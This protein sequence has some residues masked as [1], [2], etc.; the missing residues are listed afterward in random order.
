[1]L[2]EVSTQTPPGTRAI[3]MGHL[4][5]VAISPDGKTAAVAGDSGRVKLLDMATMQELGDLVGHTA[6]VV[7]VAFGPDGKSLASCGDD[8]TI[9]LWDPST[10]Q[11]RALLKGHAGPVYSV[12]FSPDGKTLA[13][14]SGDQT[15]KLWNVAT[16]QVRADLR[17]HT[18]SIWTVAFSPDGKTLASG[19]DDSTIKLWEA[20]S[21]RE[22]RTLRG[23]SSKVGSVAFSHDGG[24]L[25]S[26]D[27]L[28]MR[29]WDATTGQ[30][31]EA[32]RPIENMA[33][34]G[35][36]AALADGRTLAIGSQAA[37]KLWDV[38]TG[39]ERA[40]LNA[41]TGEISSVAISPD[42]RIIATTSYDGSAKF[43]RTA[44]EQD[45]LRQSS[46]LDLREKLGQSDTKEALQLKQDRE[47]Y[48]TNRVEQR[49]DDPLAWFDRGLFFV[50]GGQWKRAADDFQHAVKFGLDEMDYL[51][52]IAQ[53]F[54]TH[55]TRDQVLG[56]VSN[57]PGLEKLRLEPLTKR[58]GPPAIST[59]QLISCNR[60]ADH[61]RRRR[62]SAASFRGSRRS[63]ARFPERSTIASSC[64]A[65][66]T[67]WPTPFA[68]SSERRT[69][70]RSIIRPLSTTTRWSPLFRRIP[71]TV[72]SG[73]DCHRDLALMFQS[74][75]RPADAEQ[76]YR[77]ALALEEKLVADE[78]AN[79]DCRRDLAYSDFGF[80]DFLRYNKRTSEV[81]DFDRRALGLFEKLGDEFPARD[82]DRLEVGHALWRL[83]ETN[84]NLG[85]PDETEKYLRRSLAVFEKLAADF[86]QNRY[87]R[88]EQC[89]SDLDIAG[90]M[91]PLGRLK[92]AEKALRDAVDVCEKVLAQTPDDGGFQ[93]RLA[94]ATSNWR[95]CCERKTGWTR[96]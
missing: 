51:E 20:A 26:T 74:A 95:T 79:P 23:H 91:R 18:K 45:V 27:Y 66:I 38:A 75:G 61:Q 24:T 48:F 63:A 94:A 67:N 41:H 82:N 64:R 78:P 5:C 31:R 33:P 59:R 52:E 55:G 46:D 6:T 65:S 57:E 13:S 8:C 77:Q 39:R 86:P 42:N 58:H 15:V 50:S 89:F 19:G 80:A 36:C 47:A 92:D 30:P 17:G 76:E 49:P 69:R 21:G 71:H 34:M 16:R 56:A 40:T 70:N 35:P 84:W 72:S 11:E 3:S 54:E 10:R 90:L 53:F 88:W 14:G 68:T 93:D 85:R 60:R 96:R 83:G 73:L 43:W 25:F 32:L 28:T 44:T 9:R 2:W 62:S 7:G 22:L 29:T 37:L 81:E 4:W 1:M 87:C 12:D